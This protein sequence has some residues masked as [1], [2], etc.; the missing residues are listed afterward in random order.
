MIG[1]AM[2]SG[3][4]ADRQLSQTLSAIPQYCQRRLADGE[5]TRSAQILLAVSSRR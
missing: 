1:A 2:P 4:H 3:S 5:G